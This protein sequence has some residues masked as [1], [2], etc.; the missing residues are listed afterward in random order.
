MD[1]PFQLLVAGRPTLG[2]QGLR[3]VAE[4]LVVE[5]QAVGPGYVAALVGCSEL[6]IPVSAYGIS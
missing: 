3:A 4:S 2:E 5:T 6:R 1:L